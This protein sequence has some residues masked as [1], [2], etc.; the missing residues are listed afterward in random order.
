MTLVCFELEDAWTDNMKY[1]VWF[2]WIFSLFR[3]TCRILHRQVSHQVRHLPDGAK[4]LISSLLYNC[5]LCRKLR[6]KFIKQKM[7]DRPLDGMTLY[8]SFC[9]CFCR[10]TNCHQYKH[11]VV[12]P[13]PRAGHVDREWERARRIINGLL[14]KSNGQK[15]THEVLYTLMPGD[16]FKTHN[17]LILALK[18]RWCLVLIFCL[19]GSKVMYPD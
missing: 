17:Y 9:E 5:I 19:H 6:D 15:L 12:L 1:R 2:H 18:T 11:V 7:E 3:V 10:L 14:M 16:E 8:C 4:S 13:M